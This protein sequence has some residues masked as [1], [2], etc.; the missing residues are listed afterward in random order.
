[1]NLSHWIE[2]W[3]DF[4]PDKT[5]IRFEGRDISYKVFDD[6][7][8]RVAGMLHHDLDV[9][10]GDRIAFLGLNSPDMLALMFACARIGALL[11]PLN[12]RLAPPE[13]LYIL[14]RSVHEKAVK[15]FP[16]RSH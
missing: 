16:G 6:R 9:E 4:Q 7:I 10:H 3:A 12:W 14:E 2:R 5:A 1:M 15:K 11:V 8:R 13:H